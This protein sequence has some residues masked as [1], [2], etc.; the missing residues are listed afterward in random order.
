MIRRRSNSCR[1]FGKAYVDGDLV[2]EAELMALIADRDE[3]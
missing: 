3:A 2:A 1:M